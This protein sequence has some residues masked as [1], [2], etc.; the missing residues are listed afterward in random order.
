M[1]KLPYELV[2]R[3][4]VYKQKFRL[5]KPGKRSATELLNFGII[6]LDKPAG[7]KSIHCGNKIRQCLEQPK[8]GHAGTLDPLVTGVLPIG[9]GKGVKVLPVISVAGKVY[10]GRMH[11]HGDVT[12]EQLDD[13]FAKFT[14]KIMQLPPRISAVARRLR[15]REIYWLTMQKFD[16]HDVWFEVGCQAGT[17][18][19]KL[20]HDMG[21]YMKVGGHMAEL[22]RIQAGPFRIDESVSLDDVR[23]NYKKYLSTKKDT[24]IR[25]F[26]L[27]PETAV[28]HLPKV[29]VDSGVL[30]RLKNG[31]PVFA[32]GIM[33]YT[34]DLQKESTTAI[35][36]TNSNLVAIGI[37]QL[38]AF[39]MGTVT[40]GMAIK[41]DV[42]LI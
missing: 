17:Y 28:E 27:P 34:S 40:K 12:K 35:L 42:V 2:D 26:I 24:Y 37:S 7:P 3:K 14:G 10:D 31:S 8:V 30:E 38:S 25:N 6:N 1:N 19:R 29:Y 36:D 4:L 21:E 18:I 16:D 11:I 9:V 33:A 13:A 15:E 39:E 23:K 32:P 20:C 5:G 22:R 41:T